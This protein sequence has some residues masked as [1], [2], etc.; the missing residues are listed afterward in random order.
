MDRLAPPYS[1]V[2]RGEDNSPKNA[3][4]R[5]A[6]NYGYWTEATRDHAEASA[7][8]MEYLLGKLQ[9]PPAAVLDVACG[10]GESTLTLWERFGAENVVGISVEPDQL[11]LARNRGVPCRLLV[12]DAVDLDFPDQSFDA[13][14]CVEAA[15]HFRTR[16]RF[17]QR[18]FPILRNG[19]RLVMSDVLFRSGQGLDPGVFPAENIVT[20]LGD[21]QSCFV[22]AGFHPEFVTI[23]RTTQHQLLP[24]LSSMARAA[25]ILSYPRAPDFKVQTPFERWRTWFIVTRLLNVLEC[26]VVVAEKREERPGSGR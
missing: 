25:G 24:L 22:D 26:V 20:S 4:R 12:M 8:L 17:L 19:G 21:Y 3:R 13:I 9:P 15:F 1:R 5:G 16:R 14:L 2:V 18:A 10:N 23:E 7:G 11:A 6:W